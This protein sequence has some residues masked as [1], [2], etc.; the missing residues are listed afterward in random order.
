MRRVQCQRAV[1]KRGEPPNTCKT[2]VERVD[3]LVEH[4]EL[5]GINKGGD[6][7]EAPRHLV[8]GKQRRAGGRDGRRP[9]GRKSARPVAFSEFSRI[10]LIFGYVV[11]YR[12]YIYTFKAF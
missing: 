3:R 10:A 5:R 6:S 12:L 8:R 4:E 9:T 7:T 2:L 11:G 1:E